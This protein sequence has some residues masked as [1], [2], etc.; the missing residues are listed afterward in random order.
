MIVYTCPDCG[1][2]LIPVSYMTN[3]PLMAYVCHSCGWRHEESLGEKTV[4]RVPFEQAGDNTIGKILG[5]G[6]FKEVPFVH[7]EVIVTSQDGK[8]IAMLIAKQWEGDGHT[9]SI[10]ED[11]N[12]VQ[13]S[14]V[15]A[16]ALSIG[17]AAGE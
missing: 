12:S 5:A 15:V 10:K 6:E 16:G 2:D 7:K 8:D 1:A 13:A 9:V 4:R 11:T 3:P 14:Y 17:G